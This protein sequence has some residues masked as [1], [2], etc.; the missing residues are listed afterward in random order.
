MAYCNDIILNVNG[1]EY[2][3]KYSLYGN[4]IEIVDDEIYPYFD[5][6]I[7]VLKN[8]DFEDMRKFQNF[9]DEINEN[10]PFITVNFMPTA[11]NEYTCYYNVKGSE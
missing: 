7:E 5:S 11:F 10:L 6:I 4:I 3:I 8:I 1:N 9:K 2:V